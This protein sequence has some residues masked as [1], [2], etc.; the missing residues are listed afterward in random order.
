M[1][2]SREATFS[3]FGHVSTQ[4]LLSLALDIVLLATRNLDTR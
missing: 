3:D 1:T 4:F 2:Q